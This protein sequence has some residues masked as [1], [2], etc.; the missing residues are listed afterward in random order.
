MAFGTQEEG[1]LIIHSFIHIF[2]VWQTDQVVLVAQL[3]LQPGH[4]N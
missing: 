1:V 2:I 4:S 3:I